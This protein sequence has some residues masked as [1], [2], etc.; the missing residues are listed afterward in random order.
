MTSVEDSEISLVV[1][2]FSVA[3]LSDLD[4]IVAPGSVLLVEEP[5]VVTA[6]RV[7]QRIGSFPC[8]ARLQE[9]PSQEEHET[10]RIVAAVSRPPTVKAVVPGVDYGVVAAAALAEAWGL[11]GAGT[12]AARALRNKALL[13]E[14]VDGTGVAQPGWSVVSGPHE[15]A[16]F[17][18]RHGGHCVLK[19]VDRQASLGVQLLGPTDDVAAA[20][21]HTVCV[22]EPKLRARR[23]HR[24]L[25]LVEERLDGLEVSV[26]ALVS[27]GRIGFHNI[28]AKD[29]QSGRHPVE[30]G[31]V[32]PA[33]LD[34]PVQDALLRAMGLLVAAT[35][36]DTGLLHAEWILV[37][38]APYL[39]ECAGRLPGDS[40]DLLIDAAYGGSLLQKMMTVLEGGPLPPPS[41]ARRAAAIQFLV[42]EP[43]LVRRIEGMDA[44]RAVV[45]VEDV[46]L[47]VAVGDRVP[48]A[49][50]SS[51][52]RAGQVM[53]TGSDAVQARARAAEAA[54][55][56]SI[57]TER[58]DPT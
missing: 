58:H 44:A 46:E 16:D 32:L 50:A 41:T 51:W 38:G 29:T 21:Q 2:G 28:T 54:D 19:P 12:H 56:L 36:F 26:E 15:V 7:R 25:P 31:H 10:A 37:D 4:K 24:A 23:A 49:V 39:V 14:T 3:L 6:R 47:A 43:G 18:N 45:G 13:R 11:P 35:G 30:L 52:Q 9:A 1:V 34:R 40:I 17:R 22:D 27:A 57:S 48:D 8:V 53:A 33:P 5:E 20:W 42:A 55:R